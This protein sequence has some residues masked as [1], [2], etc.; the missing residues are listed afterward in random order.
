MREGKCYIGTSGWSYN[1]WTSGRFYPKGLKQADW[2]RFLSEQFNTVEV[3]SSFYHLPKL[4]VVQRWYNV[5]GARFTFAIKLWRRITHI[6]RLADCAEDLQVF[7]SRTSAL[8]AKHGPL[9]VQ[10]PPSLGCDLN[11]LEKFIHDLEEA[12]AG[13]KR[14]VVIEFRNPDWLTTPVYKILERHKAALCLADMRRCP[15]SEPN[16]VPMVY[17]RRHGPGGRYR[18][19]YSTGHI[20]ADSERVRSWLKEGRDVYVYY[21][22]DVEGYAAENARQLRERLDA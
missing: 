14:E 7:F 10:L 15:I 22:N 4:E 16:D 12:A 11:L 9:L 6:K 20:R 2:L 13:R 3:N 8:G 5:A 19:R 17:V 1:H 18:G 21:N